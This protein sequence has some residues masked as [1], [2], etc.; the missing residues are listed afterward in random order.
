MLYFPA[1]WEVFFFSCLA[2]SSRVEMTF[3]EMLTWR[4]LVN[5][6]AFW[7]IRSMNFQQMLGVQKVTR[8]LVP[9]QK[10]PGG[11]DGGFVSMN[12]SW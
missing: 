10:P 11:L 12:R 2:Q 8:G 7:C 3:L 4:G 1:C 9:T 6:L 5:N